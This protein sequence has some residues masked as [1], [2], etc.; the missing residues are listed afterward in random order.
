[1]EDGQGHDYPYDL[2]DELNFDGYEE[3]EDPEILGQQLTQMLAPRVEAHAPTPTT[4]AVP[5][6]SQPILAPVLPS[7]ETQA[8]DGEGAWQPVPSWARD[9]SR[10]SYPYSS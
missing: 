2:D 10:R 7:A 6:G 9:V 3:P 8:D 1:M 5:E 4:P